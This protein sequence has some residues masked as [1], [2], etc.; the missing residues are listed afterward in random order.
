MRAW[1]IK[2]EKYIYI[3]SGGF[4]ILLLFIGSFLFLIQCA[5]N[6]KNENQIEA[7]YTSIPPIVDGN[8]D[9]SVWLQAAPIVLK[10]NRSGKNVSDPQLMTRVMTCYDDNTLYISFICSDPDI[11]TNYTQRDEYLWEEEAVEV[12]IDV[13]DVPETY[14][15]IEVSPANVL[16]D[17][18]N[19]FWSLNGNVSWPV[20]Y[21]RCFGQQPT[22]FVPFKHNGI[23]FC[24]RTIDRG[25]GTSRARTDNNQWH[26]PFFGQCMRHIN[27]T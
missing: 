16:F 9:D 26:H 6:N 20:L 23:Y 17:I 10:E 27:D 25:T 5:G 8:P 4:K 22:R 24:P 14:V 7:I 19:N 18:G 2:N 11:W 12:F 3:K 1:I 21:F 13:D 15:E